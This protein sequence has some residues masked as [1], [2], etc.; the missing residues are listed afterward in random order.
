MGTHHGNISWEHADTQVYMFTY[1]SD[2]L[3][4]NSDREFGSSRFVFAR[5][6]D[7]H[8]ALS[9]PV[10]FYPFACWSV[11]KLTGLCVRSWAALRVYVGGL[12][13]VLGPMLAVLGRS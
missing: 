4:L 10:V 11:V 5:E 2:G 6:I 9:M 7:G 8:H 3:P 13:A 1:T 12:G